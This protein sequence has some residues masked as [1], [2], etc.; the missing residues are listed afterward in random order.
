VLISMAVGK[1]FTEQYAR[2]TVPE[3]YW[4]SPEFVRTNYVITGAWAGAFAVMVLAD[5]VLLFRP[6]IPPKFGIIATVLAIVGAVK[7]T[8]WYPDRASR[9]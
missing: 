4:G 2:D 7:F 6:D 1:P 9:A 8:G 3:E 5:L